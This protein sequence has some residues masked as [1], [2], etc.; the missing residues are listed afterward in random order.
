MEVSTTGKNC[1]PPRECRLVQA[2][3]AGKIDVPLDPTLG[4]CF[5]AQLLTEN[6]RPA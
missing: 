6:L 4:Q 2:F 5:G 3:L 1:Q